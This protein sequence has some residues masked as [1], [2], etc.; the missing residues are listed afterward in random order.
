[1][2]AFFKTTPVNFS[3]NLLWNLTLLA[4]NLDK[5]TAKQAN[6]TKSLEKIAIG[7]GVILSCCLGYKLFQCIQQSMRRGYVATN[8]QECINAFCGAPTII[9]ASQCATEQL[10][11]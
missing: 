10:C 3:I 9:I 5:A 4:L 7:T 1:M 11:P 6:E 8:Q 2:F